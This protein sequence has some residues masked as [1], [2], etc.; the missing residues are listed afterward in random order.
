MNTL[1][2]ILMVSNTVKIE[3]R[4]I[5]HL[6][7]EVS[8]VDYSSKAKSSNVRDFA[9]AKNTVHSVNEV[10]ITKKGNE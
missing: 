1:L 5:L 6:K 10:T 7:A 8:K 9:A 2:L 3:P 4:F